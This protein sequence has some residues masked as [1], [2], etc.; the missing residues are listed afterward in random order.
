MVGVIREGHEHTVG[1]NMPKKVKGK[2]RGWHEDSAG[3]SRAAKMR[4]SKKMKST[5]GRRYAKRVGKLEQT[6]KG[7]R[8]RIPGFTLGW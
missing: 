4:K 1:G 8:R 5:E 2:G 7:Y 3:H 6:L